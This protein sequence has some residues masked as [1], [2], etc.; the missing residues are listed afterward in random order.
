MK[1]KTRG[2]IKQTL[3][4]ARPML[5]QGATEYLVLLAVVLVIALVAITLLGFFTGT[6]SNNQITQS[7][8]YWQ[9]AAPISVVEATARYTHGWG[10]GSEIAI[11]FRNNGGYPIRITKLLGGKNNSISTFLCR[12]ASCG[13]DTYR[14]ISDFYY[15]AP[16]EEKTLKGSTFGGQ[17]MIITTSESTNTA[18]TTYLFSAASAKCKSPSSS[19]NGTQFLIDIANNPSYDWGTLEIKDFGFEYIMYVDGV[20]ITKRQIGKPLMVECTTAVW[21]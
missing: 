8:T 1:A 11:R 13:I 18:S 6:A 16:S 14:N 17:H 12:H 7:K 4:A 5:G 15:L 20:E 21:S 19:S 3:P 9:S 10:R 2:A